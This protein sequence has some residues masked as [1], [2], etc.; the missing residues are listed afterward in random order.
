[1]TSKKMSVSG[2]SPARPR[3]IE[4]MATKGL[5]PRMQM[6]TLDSVRSLAKHCGVGCHKIRA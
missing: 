4:V 2:E 6:L 1:M 3:V 5:S